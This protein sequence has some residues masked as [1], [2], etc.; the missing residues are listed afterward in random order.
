MLLGGYTGDLQ[1]MNGAQ[2]LANFRNDGQMFIPRQDYGMAS[3]G[4]IS[5][6]DLLSVLELKC[7]L[8]LKQTRI[9][10]PRAECVF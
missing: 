2:Q 4:K 7:N 1:A 10:Y 3:G 5:K 6:K 9:W 8:R